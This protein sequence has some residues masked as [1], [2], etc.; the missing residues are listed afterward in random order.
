MRSLG[1]ER[2][3][4][5]KMLNNEATPQS[6]RADFSGCLQKFI[7]VSG[8]LFLLVIHPK[9]G[10]LPRREAYPSRKKAACMKMFKSTEND[11]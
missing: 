7:F 1:V 11:S 6:P 10:I 4:P 2:M 8:A 3:L 9:G 5:G